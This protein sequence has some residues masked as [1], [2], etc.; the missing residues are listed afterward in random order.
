M[1]LDEPILS[2]D[3]PVHYGYAYVADGKVIS[4][5]IQGTVAGLKKELNAK[6]IRRCDIFGRQE[7]EEKTYILKKDCPKI[8]K[9]IGDYYNGEFGDNIEELLVKGIIEEERIEK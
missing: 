4:S 5:N 6:E 3:Y 1:S 8:G 9:E 7:K 2:D